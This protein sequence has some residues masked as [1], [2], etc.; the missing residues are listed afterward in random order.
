MGFVLG[1]QGV[2]ISCYL[3][4]VSQHIEKLQGGFSADI[5]GQKNSPPWL[6]QG[7]KDVHKGFKRVLSIDHFWPTLPR[8]CFWPKPLYH[9]CHQFLWWSPRE[10]P[11]LETAPH[12]FLR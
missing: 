3:K 12:V 11:L 5:P 7:L 8:L 10:A 4:I 9:A 1:T 2:T 6:Q